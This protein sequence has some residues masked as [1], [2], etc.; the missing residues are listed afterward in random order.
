MERRLAEIPV[1]EWDDLSIDITP[2]EYVLLYLANGFPT[3][4]YE[5]YADDEG[6][7]LSRP[8]TLDGQPVQSRV[9]VE[10]RDRL[11]EKLASLPPVQ[12][13]LDQILHH[14]GAEQVAEVTGR[15][16]RIVKKVAAGGQARL[17]VENRPGSANLAETQSFMDDKK[18]ILVF[19]DAGGTGRS[20]H[21]DLSA[22]NQRKRVHY[23]LEP[24]WKADTAIQGLG[25]SNRT[26]QAQPPLFRPVATN[27]KGEKRF[28]STIAKRLDSLGAITRGQRQTGGQGL[29]RPEDNLESAYARAALIELYTRIYDGKVAFST[30][31]D[32][33]NA[34][35]LRIAASDGTMLEE[36]PPIT[37]FLNRVLALPIAL[38]NRFFELFEEL[39]S[40]RVEAAIA[41]G[42][43]DI[44][45][46]TL[47]AESLLVTERRV[48]HTHERT[49]ATTSLLTIRREDKNEPM[50]LEAVLAVAKSSG[51]SF[52][53]NASSH[54]AALQIPTSSLTLDDGRVEE[55]VRLIRP[56]SR[57]AVSKTRLAASHWQI[58][59]ED[60]FT[61]L[62]LKELQ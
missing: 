32:F 24:G 11:I 15:N 23:L 26:N 7:I 54:R 35:G 60:E 45:L 12:T 57:D 56:L 36:L 18:R 27:V 43:Y 34:T 25:R 29:F 49:G 6:N 22:R 61:A 59:T 20:Y 58:A 46:E 8:V 3:Q 40:I 31:G 37:T 53:V 10:I 19:S 39:L 21:A 50:S 62:W 52:L 4:L 44:G 55:R 30:L 41:S 28:L 48:L 51:S 17:A 47:I 14:F 9:A 2:R 16:R 38:Q 5:R 42:T 33:E 13:A 1:S